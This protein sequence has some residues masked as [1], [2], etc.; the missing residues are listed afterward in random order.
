MVDKHNQSALWHSLEIGQSHAASR[1]SGQT[2]SLQSAH[3]ALC[4]HVKQIHL[5]NLRRYMR[6][7]LMTAG[8]N[9]AMDEQW[10][11]TCPFHVPNGTYFHKPEWMNERHR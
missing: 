2:C 4:M 11:V 5:I 9:E 7:M 8:Q 1:V 3:A 6:Y 10:D